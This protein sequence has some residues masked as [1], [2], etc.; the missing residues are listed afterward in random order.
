MPLSRK[1]GAKLSKSAISKSQEFMNQTRRRGEDRRKIGTVRRAK[2]K[3]T[4]YASIAQPAG[5][6]LDAEL[7]IGNTGIKSNLRSGTIVYAGNSNNNSIEPGV[8][9]EIYSVPIKHPSR[10]GAP[11]LPSG[12]GAPALPS[13]SGAPA[14]P[15]GSGAPAPKIKR[16]PLPPKTVETPL[17]RS[18]GVTARRLIPPE[19]TYCNHL[20]I[21]IYNKYKTDNLNEIATKMLRGNDIELH[22]RLSELFTTYI[23]IKEKNG[24][25]ITEIENILRKLHYELQVIQRQ[26]APLTAANAPNTEWQQSTRLG[27]INRRK[28]K[29]TKKRKLK[30]KKK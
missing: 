22:K 13:R 30:K 8:P 21:D 16:P 19:E 1:P 12:S 3:K 28:S 17:S 2:K 7:N 29:K 23:D 25:R 26:K 9:D 24:E 15:S 27:K 11:A 10:S 6:T 14:L 20:L 4:E 5:K 18:S